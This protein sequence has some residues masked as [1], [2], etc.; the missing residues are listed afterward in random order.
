MYT[1]YG[2]PLV[3]V[4]ETTKVG[5]VLKLC[6]E[7]VGFPMSTC[8]APRRHDSVTLVWITPCPLEGRGAQAAPRHSLWRDTVTQ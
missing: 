2:F 6:L 5:C 1:K 7:P 4:Y 3:G 8:A